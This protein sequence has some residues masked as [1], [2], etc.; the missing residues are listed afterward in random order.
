MS[1]SSIEGMASGRPFIA[2]DV[3]GLR[4]I[5]DGYGLLFPHQDAQ[6]LANEIKSLCENQEK[7][8][9]IAKSCQERAKQFDINIMA[10]KYNEVYYKII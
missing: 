4:E 8:N 7:Y 10:E 2:S 3:D 6:V 5:V 1:L 9:K